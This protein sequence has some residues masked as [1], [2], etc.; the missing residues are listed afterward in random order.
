[1]APLARSLTPRREAAAPTDWMEQKYKIRV[2]PADGITA[3]ESSLN[4][5][6]AVT[7][8]GSSTK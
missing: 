2:A 1:V 4:G 6:S 3:A 7:V 8:Y 5:V